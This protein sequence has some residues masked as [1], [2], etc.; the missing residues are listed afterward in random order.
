M[1]AN[2]QLDG[3]NPR[4]KRTCIC[5]GMTTNIGGTTRH[6]IMGDYISNTSS[7]WTLC[8]IAIVLFVMFPA[9]C[10]SVLVIN[11][12]GG[13]GAI[14]RDNSF[15]LDLD[16]ANVCSRTS[17]R[18]ATSLLSS[19]NEVTSMCNSIYSPATCSALRSSIISTDELYLPLVNYTC[20]DGFLLE[21]NACP[22]V[23]PSNTFGRD[24]SSSCNC[25]NG[26]T[27]NAKNGTC[28]CGPGWRGPHC[29]LTCPPG[30]YG[31]GCQDVCECQNGGSCN[32]TSGLCL[33][34]SGFAGDKCEVNCRRSASTITGCSDDF[35]CE[36]CEN[37]STDR[38][39]CDPLLGSCVC[40]DGWQGR[41]CAHSCNGSTHGRFCLDGCDCENSDLCW[42]VDGR[43][44]CRP[45]WTGDRCDKEC[46][47][48]SFG[49][50][51]LRSCSCPDGAV[52]DH[53]HG[54]CGSCP[55]GWNG[56]VCAL[57]CIDD[58]WG[59]D[60]TQDCGCSD[61]QDCEPISGRCFNPD[62]GPSTNPSSIV[63]IAASTGVAVAVV[64][65]VIAIVVTM[66][67][68]KKRTSVQNP[69]LS[70]VNGAAVQNGSAT[71]N[72]NERYSGPSPPPRDP[73]TLP[74]SRNTSERDS[75]R[76]EYIPGTH[77]P[78]SYLDIYEDSSQIDNH[79]YQ[80]GNSGYEVPS[81]NGTLERALERQ[82]NPRRSQSRV[83]NPLYGG[84][85][86][87]EVPTPTLERRSDGGLNPR[88]SQSRVANPLYGENAG[89][90]V[91]TPNGTLERA[92][93]D[94]ADDGDYT[95]M[96]APSSRTDDTYTDLTM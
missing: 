95:Y 43:C 79:L 24:C 94:R 34:Q 89:Y 62:G 1:V 51:C 32:R 72:L 28:H 76:Y 78:N 23:C 49:A 55:A 65:I 33:C 35:H 7:T 90:E 69:R 50:G 37:V 57:P 86:G 81:P 31:D 19:A 11:D 75:H 84:N 26:A 30:R 14:W 85:A 10:D 17:L 22:N 47:N 15:N 40:A 96:T 88:Q 83:A 27:C 73:S 92:V 71:S 5:N 74:P 63:I 60:C 59:P 64:A 42:P 52:C 66:K 36:R 58:E 68:R 77:R 29:E 38:G 61:D 8:L 48:G 82:Q 21:G 87:Y 44:E 45:G 6:R 53:V 20:C 46:P 9:L 93:D 54:G 2:V 12:N 67:R 4:F 56:H 25:Q 80:P 41:F 3:R 70:L 91:P 18:L 13:F 16:G 39:V